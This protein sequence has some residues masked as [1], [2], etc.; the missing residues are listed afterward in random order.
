MLWYVCLNFYYFRFYCITIRIYDLYRFFWKKK[1]KIFHGLYYWIKVF[2]TVPWWLLCTI[3]SWIGLYLFNSIYFMIFKSYI[4]LLFFNSSSAKHWEGWNSHRI[5][6][7]SISQVS[8]YLIYWNATWIVIYMFDNSLRI[9]TDNNE[10][11]ALTHLFFCPEFRFTLNYYFH[12]CFL[13][14]F[15][16]P[17]TY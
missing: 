13:K 15:W 12:L 2:A 17:S 7:L 14:N 6:F 10:N 16:L 5:L 8:K 4:P 11:D 9:L 1:F 3:L